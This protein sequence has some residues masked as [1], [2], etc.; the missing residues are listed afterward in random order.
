MVNFYY[1]R[2]K[3]GVNIPNG[4]AKEHVK[5]YFPEFRPTEFRKMTDFEPAVYPSDF[6][7]SSEYMTTKP[8][9]SIKESSTECLGIYPIEGFGSAQRAVGAS[10][11]WNKKFKTSLDYMSDKAK[12]YLKDGTLKFYFGLIQEAFINDK[13]FIELHKCMKQYEITNGNVVVND[14]LAENRYKNWCKKN[15]EKVRFSVTVFSHSLFEKSYEAFE[16]LNQHNVYSGM[17]SEYEKHTSSAMSYDEFLNTKEIKREKHLLCLNRRQREHRLATL[18]VLSKNNLLKN[19]NVSFQFTIDQH[20]PY[21]IEHIITDKK[22]FKDLKIEY[23]KLK[24]M[25]YQYVDYPIA[26]EA[27]DGIHHGYGWEN[28]KPY[29]DTYFSIVTETAFLNPTGY[30]SEKTWRPISFFHPFIL[31]GSPGSLKFIKKFGFKTFSPFIDE[32]YD[33]KKTPTE[34]FKLIEDEIVRLGK[35]S[36]EEIHD[37]YW[38]MEDIL[39]YNYNLLMDYGKNNSEIYKNFIKNIFNLSNGIF[40]PE[41]EKNNSVFKD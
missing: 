13:E 25:K 41:L 18:C 7:S 39:I 10:P 12:Q 32:S 31:V 15:K 4:I 34:R 23:D 29:L 2:V 9:S 11:R 14:F 36:K 21:Y 40:I 27:K 37:W 19:N 1:D 22:K 26:M 33:N 17:A 35:M 20:T 24:K 28:H 3:D 30:V 16:L 5:F 6:Q 8:V 38:S